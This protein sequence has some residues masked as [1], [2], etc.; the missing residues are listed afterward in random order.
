MKLIIYKN[1]RISVSENTFANLNYFFNP[2]IIQHIEELKRL[3]VLYDEHKHLP[4]KWKKSSKSIK[5]ENRT[6]YDLKKIFYDTI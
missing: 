6:L 3:R 5:V 4:K 1:E 2:D